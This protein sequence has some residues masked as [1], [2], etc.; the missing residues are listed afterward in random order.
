MKSKEITGNVR[1]F[2]ESFGSPEDAPI[3]LIMGATASGVWWAE[4]FCGQLAATGRFVIR[5]DHRDTGRSMSYLPGQINYSVEDLADDA[6]AVLDGYGLADAHLVGM[7]LGGFLAQLLA[8]R[9]PQRV[10]SMTLIASERLAETDP[11][12]PAMNSSVLDYF[13]KAAEVDWTNQESVVEYQVG[14]WRLLSGSAHQFDKKLIRELAEADFERTPNLL[15]TF[16]HALL[17]GGE[18]WMNRLREIEV[19]TLIIHGT[20]DSVLPYAHALALKTEITHSRLLR[21]NGTGHELHPEDWHTIIQAI[22]QHTSSKAFVNLS[23][24]G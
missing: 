22:E 4:E 20:E 16:N 17:T 23:T 7:S 14:L 15:T 21:L 19:S 13:A 2:S 10:K 3:L 6:L 18:K 1:L 24:T 12:L 8:L 11:T 9:N 5:Y